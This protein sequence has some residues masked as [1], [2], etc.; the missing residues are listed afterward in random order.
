MLNGGALASP[1]D[2]PVYAAYPSRRRKAASRCK[3]ARTGG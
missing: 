3:S 1:F 2:F